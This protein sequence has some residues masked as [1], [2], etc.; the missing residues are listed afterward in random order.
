VAVS[1][2]CGDGYGIHVWLLA[3]CGHRQEGIPQGLKPDFVT[4]QKPKAKALGY[5]EA[6][7]KATFS[8]LGYLKATAKTTFSALGY[9]DATA[10][11]DKGAMGG[12]SERT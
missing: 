10:R 5:L 2:E 7:A 11:T 9:P 12:L 1:L 8:A 4:G 3:D 6:T